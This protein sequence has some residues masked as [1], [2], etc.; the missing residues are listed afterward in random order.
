MNYQVCSEKPYSHSDLMNSFA[1]KAGW[2]FSGRP[3]EAN[4]KNIILPRLKTLIQPDLE[5]RKYIGL[6]RLKKS[7]QK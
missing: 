3:L 1:T 5:K 4:Q 6:L 2:T 7:Q